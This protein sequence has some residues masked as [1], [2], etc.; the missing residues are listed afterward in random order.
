M[1]A[2]GILPFPVYESAFKHL[3]NRWERGQK[4]AE[5][6]GATDACRE[7]NWLKR[8]ESGYLACDKST[9][10]MEESG[11]KNFVKGGSRKKVWNKSIDIFHPLYT[12][13]I[14]ALQQSARADGYEKDV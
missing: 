2:E 14:S 13:A 7:R 1:W 4:V 11:K 12:S 5:E 10:I 8:R 6:R 3:T 9:A